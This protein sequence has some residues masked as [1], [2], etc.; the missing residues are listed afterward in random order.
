LISKTVQNTGGQSLGEINNVILNEKGKVVAVTIGVG[1]LLGLGEKDVGV[2]FDAL[3]FRSEEAMEKK[4]E[5]DANDKAKAED[6]TAANEAAETDDADHSDMVI[7]LDATKEQLAAA[8]SFK[9][10]GEKTE[11]RADTETGKH[12]E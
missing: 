5:A 7:V 9:W 11:K 2:P 6:M 10:L 12:V 1:G 4:V 3:K 8:P